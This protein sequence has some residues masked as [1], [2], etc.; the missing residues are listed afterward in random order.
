MYSSAAVDTVR[1]QHFSSFPKRFFSSL[2]PGVLTKTDRERYS[3]GSTAPDRVWL[4]E[5]PERAQ[6]LFSFVD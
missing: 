3:M 6:P 1:F 4:I 2:I 5:Q